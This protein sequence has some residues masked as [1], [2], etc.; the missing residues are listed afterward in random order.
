M[1]SKNHI[2]K[3]L[4]IFNWLYKKIN[5]LSSKLP[6]LKQ[7]LPD[8][9]QNTGLYVPL[10]HFYS[11]IPSLDYLNQHRD[12]IFKPLSKDIP[13]VNLREKEQLELLRSFK[14]YYDN[15][16]FPHEK[17]KDLRY[18]FQNPSYSYL[19]AIFLYS[20]IRHKKPKN[21]IEIGSGY[22]TCVILDTNDL[23][24]NGNI[25]V[26]CIEPYPELLL[27]LLKKGDEGRINLIAKDIQEVDLNIFSC[28]EENDI[29]LIDSTHVSKIYSDVNC[30]FFEILPSLASG[31]LI[32]FH[33]I[34]YPFEYPTDWVFENRA[35]NELYI[36]RAFLQYNDAFRIVLF[37]SYLMNFF[38]DYFREHM[39]LCLRN[40]GGNIWIQRN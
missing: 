10:G 3:G 12:K 14:T 33:D 28:L 37:S 30:A 13:G 38:E 2:I 32:H 5:E 39:P 29:L 40:A 16:P 25:N 11:P 24:F 1:K 27:S 17:E 20:M 23:H 22:S 15:Q 36:L 4:P 35:W 21:I 9:K 8:V 19:D 6:E 26:T 18:F 7:K 31:V 34:F